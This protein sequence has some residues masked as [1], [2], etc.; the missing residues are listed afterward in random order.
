MN[1]LCVATEKCGGYKKLAR[2]AASTRLPDAGSIQLTDDSTVAVNNFMLLRVACA[3]TRKGSGDERVRGPIVL[4]LM[5]TGSRAVQGSG[6]SLIT[7]IWPSARV[8]DQISQV[9]LLDIRDFTAD[10]QK[11]MMTVE[12]LP[13]T[14]KYISSE[15]STMKPCNQQ[16]HLCQG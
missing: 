5:G 9:P 8:A 7:G 16:Q 4:L 2:S 3:M 12:N 6:H 10:F 1:Y 14:A 11:L 15:Q 13:L